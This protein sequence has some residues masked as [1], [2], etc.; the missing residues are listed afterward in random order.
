VYLVAYDPEQLFAYWDV[1]WNGGPAT[2]YALH[3]CRADG[4]VEQTV[5]IGAAEAGK[6]CA[7]GQPGG[8]YFVELGRHARDGQWQVLATSTRVTMPPTGLAGSG[9]AKF[10]TLPFHLS[11]QRLLEL[12]E[13]TMGTGEDLTAALARLQRADRAGLDALVGTLS[14]LGP[15]PLETLEALLGQ[16]FHVDSESQSSLSSG[17]HLRDRHDVLAAGAFSSE[18]LSSANLSSGGAFGS[19]V[20]SVGSGAAGASESLSSGGFSSGGLAGG[21]VAGV[22]SETLASGAFSSG[23]FS[24]GLSG[25]TQARGAFSSGEL[26][27]GIGSETLSSGAFSSDTAGGLTGLGFGSETLASGSFASGLSGGSET[28]AAY[29]AGLSSES[30]SSYGA[31]FGSAGSGGA[32]DRAADERAAGFLKIIESQLARLGSLFSGSGSGGV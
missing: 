12:I 15:E 25:E 14:R 17:G 29:A 3:V 28:L 10:A 1:D 31:D 21:L 13:E 18:G 9:D 30:L 20:E 6:Y 24:G 32:S 22:G 2:P 11:F 5:T 26:L 16:K 4:S 27:G 23:E 19:S 7:V 8:T